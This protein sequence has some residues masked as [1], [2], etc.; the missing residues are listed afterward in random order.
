MEFNNC[1]IIRSP[2]LFS[3]LNHSDSTG[4][5]SA[6]FRT[7]ARAWLQ[8]RMSRVLFAVKHTAHVQTIICRQ[9]LSGHVVASA[10]EKGEGNVANRGYF[11]N[12]NKENYMRACFNHMIIARR[13]SPSTRLK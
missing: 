12:F 7:R 9:L 10:I 6:I 2:S 4:K 8:L 3:Y 5:L 1:F 11:N 13:E